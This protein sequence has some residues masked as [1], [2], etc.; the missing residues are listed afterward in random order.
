[1]QQFK[2]AFVGQLSTEELSRAFRVVIHGLLHEI[3]CVDA[4][5]A[6]RLRSPLLSLTDSSEV[7]P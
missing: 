7:T 2:D 1:M 6:E 3:Q 4:E 5:L